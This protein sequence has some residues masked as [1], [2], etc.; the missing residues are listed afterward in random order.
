MDIEEVRYLANQAAA[1]FGGRVVSRVGHHADGVPDSLVG[2]CIPGSSPL[3]D[4][5][6]RDGHG[7]VVPA[8]GPAGDAARGFLDGWNG[9]VTSAQGVPLA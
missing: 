3:P 5:W 9:R 8:D 6:V 4:G 7:T 2:L 1:G